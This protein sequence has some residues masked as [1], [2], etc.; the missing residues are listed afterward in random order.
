[1]ISSRSESTKV[2]ELSLK[3]GGTGSIITNDSTEGV[4]KSNAVHSNPTMILRLDMGTRMKPL[5][6]IFIFFIILISG[7]DDA[8]VMIDNHPVDYRVAYFG[9]ES[10]SLYVIKLDGKQNYTKVKFSYRGSSVEWIPNSRS[11]IFSEI[12]S[13]YVSTVWLFDCSTGQKT[14][15]RSFPND[16]IAGIMIAPDGRSFC[17]TK[18]PQDNSGRT[19]CIYDLQG[20]LLRTITSPN[21]L[22]YNKTWS[23]DGKSILFRIVDTANTYHSILWSYDLAGARRS[24]IFDTR[25]SIFSISY[26]P[27]GA[28]IV[29]SVF[30][31]TGSSALGM[32]NADGSN[33][34]LVVPFSFSVLGPVWSPDGKNIAFLNGSPIYTKATVLNLE[35]MDLRQISTATGVDFDVRWVDK[36]RVAFFT[37][38]LTNLCVVSKDGS[39][40][41][42]ITNMSPEQAG[43]WFNYAV[44][45]MAF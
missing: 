30:D 16:Y 15:I 18:F 20:V 6:L 22:A 44:S 12:S 32:M 19:I 24:L 8:P 39:G 40:F 42:Q 7:C 43:G 1:M 37:N 23:P 34:H 3:S 17:C 11:I 9:G 10:D 26:S 4:T 13:K 27:D 29:M 33:F 28:R 36:E 38:G 35:T 45:S 14:L 5:T 41:S 31:S 25:F 21:E 2:D